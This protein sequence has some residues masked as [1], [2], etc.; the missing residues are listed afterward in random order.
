MECYAIMLYLGNPNHTLIT[1]RKDHQYIKKIDTFFSDFKEHELVK[2][3]SKTYPSDNS[4]WINNLEAH[5]NLKALCSYDSL[6]TGKI[7]KFPIMLAPQLATIVKK[8]AE[9]SNFMKF[10]N[11]NTEFYNAMKNIILTNYAFGA[12]IIEF[13]N[14]NFNNEIINFLYKISEIFLN[15]D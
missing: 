2:D 11:E 4:N 14:E 5:Y 3:L 7:D 15:L 12:N 8:F 13:F 6:N 10:Y 9:E 1:W